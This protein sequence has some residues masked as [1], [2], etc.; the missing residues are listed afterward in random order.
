[1]TLFL[2]DLP[3]PGSPIFKRRKWRRCFFAYGVSRE[4]E[5]E[6]GWWFL[7]ARLNAI[8]KKDPHPTSSHEGERLRFHPKIK[9]A[10]L[11]EERLLIV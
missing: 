1:M 4:L 7:Y 8:D 5:T 3:P 6:D 11:I 10:V 9:K 2:A